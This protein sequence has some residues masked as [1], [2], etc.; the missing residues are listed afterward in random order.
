MELRARG[1]TVAAAR[2][3]VGVSRSAGA[4]WSRGFK[5]YRNGQVVGFTPP[6]DRLEVRAI[7]ARYLSEDE[8]LLIADLRRQGLGV[9]AIAEQVARSPSTISR[10]LRRNRHLD[11]T[12]RPFEAHRQ[13]VQRRAKPRPRRLQSNLLLRALVGQLLGQRWS[14]SQIARHLRSR[15]PDDPWMRVCHETIYQALYQPGP[16]ITRP[17]AVPSPQRPSPLR[18]GRDHRRAQRRA[19]QRRPR[20]GRPMFTIHDRP[21]P[22]E[23]R[24]QAG[25][26]E[27]DLI[28]GGRRH[29]HESAIG[30]LVERQ[31]RLI[32]L[33]HLPSRDAAALHAALAARMRDL[34][35]HLI[36]SITWD[37][38]TEMAAHRDISAELG[39][40]VYFC[41]AHSPW[42][43]GT[44]ENSNGLL[45]QYFPK[46][47]DLRH[48]SPEHLLAVE[49]ELNHRPRAVLNDRT[50]AELFAALLAS[51]NQPPLRR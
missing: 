26:W 3:E 22:P 32:R 27:G 35:A 25:H 7:S 30:T 20:F 49:D 4:N 38:G 9:R 13:A 1:W 51:P 48:H 34:P 17:P 23:D 29:G 14:P 44:N 33:I 41:D 2:R 36:R 15:F 37:Q 12:Y 50:P 46:G 11:G 8:R 39:A 19:D 28:I 10:E 24:A 42:Q 47:T 21:F 18:T 31:T 5:T 45:R 16:A 43:R 40:A 6:L